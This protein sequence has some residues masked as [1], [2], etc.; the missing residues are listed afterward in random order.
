MKNFLLFSL[1]ILSKIG[2]SD[3]PLTSTDFYKAYS[4]EEMVIHV[5]ERGFDQYFVEFLLNKRKD[6]VIKIAAIN[7][8]G[9]GQSTY[10]QEFERYLLK[11]R[12]GLQPQVFD[13]LRSTEVSDEQKGNLSFLKGDDLLCWA[14]L[15]A[16]SD[17]DNPEKAL[18]A[19]KVAAEREPKSMAPA[20]VYTLIA[21]QVAFDSEWCEVYNL[22]VKNLKNTTYKNDTL[23]QDAI[24]IIMDY[25]DLYKTYCEK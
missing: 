11:N 2:F 15:Q 4:S 1:L 17:Y 20:V 12:S 10:I 19:A 6:P 21:G 9:W 3:S 16:M 18:Y 7:A 5:Q 8:L 14:Y 22:G 24:Q 23:K 13:F 25:L